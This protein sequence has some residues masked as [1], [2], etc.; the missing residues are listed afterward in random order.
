[1]DAILNKLKEFKKI[2][3]FILFGMCALYYFCAF[4]YNITND[5]GV[6]SIFAQLAQGF[7]VCAILAIGLIGYL[8]KK[9][10]FCELAFALILGGGVYNLIV[11]FLSNLQQFDLFKYYSTSLILYYVFLFLTSL[12][13]TAFAACLVLNWLIGRD[14][15]R[16]IVAIIGIAWIGMTALMIIFSIVVVADGAGWIRIVAAFYDLA[17]GVFLVVLAITGTLA[18]EETAAPVAA[19]PAKEDKAEAPAEE[20]PA[21]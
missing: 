7:A 6:G 16:N 12:V 20:T 2:V 9:E 15:L 13:G 1:M 21:E 11:G 18:Y 14:A 4:I 3:F 17:E 10:K 19:A 8:M 5:A